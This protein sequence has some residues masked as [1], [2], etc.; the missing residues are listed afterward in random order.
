MER[1]MDRVAHELRLD[2]ADLRRRNYI[3]PEQMPY[4]VGLI[5]RDGKPLIYDS[6]DYP[7][8]HD[9]A[10]ELGGYRK[11][12]E[13]QAEARARGHYIG[14]GVA[15]YV[16]GTGLGPFEGVTVRILPDGKGRVASG[17]TSHGQ[18]PRTTLAHVVPEPV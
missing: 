4:S 7:R 3:R 5:F 2:P 8:G 6:G 9:A 16:E 13:R 14:I 12:P 1:L 17:A 11:F 18:G 10:L 15:S